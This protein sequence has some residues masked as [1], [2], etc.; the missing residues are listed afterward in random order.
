MKRQSILVI[1]FILLGIAPKAQCDL[2][3]T[4]GGIVYDS[5]TGKYWIRS[6]T[7]FINQTYDEQIASIAALGN[8]G[9]KTG[10]H[11]ATLAEMQ[12]LW[13]YSAYDIAHNFEPSWKY[14][15]LFEFWEARYDEPSSG[16]TD[17][18]Y[19]TELWSEFGGEKPPP[20]YKTWVKFPLPGGAWPDSYS[21]SGEPSG[22]VGAWVVTP[23]PPAILLGVIGLVVAGVKLRQFT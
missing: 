6:L 22:K 15:W 9:N 19:G 21:A 5:A 10:W 11:M 23:V 2:I 13:K 17:W 14:V 7:M 4:A 16:W 12:E 18:H 8:Y 20:E 1:F 3:P